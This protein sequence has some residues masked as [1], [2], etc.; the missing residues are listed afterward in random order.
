MSCECGGEGFCVFCCEERDKENR[1]SRIEQR[2]SELEDRLTA[3]VE[4]LDESE[5]T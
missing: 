2:L 4:R 3:L 1:L 5:E